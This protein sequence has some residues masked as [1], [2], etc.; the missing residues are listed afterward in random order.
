MYI[1]PEMLN[2]LYI[3]RTITL[4][5]DLFLWHKLANDALHDTNQSAFLAGWLLES[6]HYLQAML[7]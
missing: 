1:F 7:F 4:W 5:K 3:S 2:Y 6:S